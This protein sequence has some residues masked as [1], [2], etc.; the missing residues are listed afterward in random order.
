MVCGI[1]FRVIGYMFWLLSAIVC[2]LAAL[3]TI[4]LWRALKAELISRSLTETFAAFAKNSV[5]IYRHEHEV[6]A[7]WSAAAPSADYKWRVDVSDRQRDHTD[8]RTSSQLFPATTFEWSL[9][10]GHQIWSWISTF[11][12]RVSGDAGPRIAFVTSRIG[13]CNV[14]LAGAQKAAT[15]KLHRLLNAAART[16]IR[17]SLV[18]IWGSL[19]LSTFID[20]KCRNEWSSSSWRWCITAFITRLPGTSWITAFQSLMWPVDDIFVLTGVITSLC[21]D[22]VSAPYG[23]WALLLP[24]WPHVVLSTFSLPLENCSHHATVN[25][26]SRKTLR[27]TLDAFHIHSKCLLV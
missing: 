27:R 6:V 24:V 4:K 26:R 2:C 1:I 20:S 11:G 10:H 12:F 21:L 13:Y 25:C 15:D 18:A 5:K 7:L 16:T 3:Q 8:G 22:T 14:L 17:E 23:R 19:C 9:W